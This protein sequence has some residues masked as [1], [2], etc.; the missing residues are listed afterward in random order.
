MKGFPMDAPKATGEVQR[1][2]LVR[3]LHE[4]QMDATLRE[5]E[6][7]SEADAS[8]SSSFCPEDENSKPG[9]S[10]SP[11]NLEA[12]QVRLLHPRH[13]PL[14]IGPLYVALIYAGQTETFMAAPF[15]R[16]S[17]PAMEAE[18]RI[19]R[20][21]PCLRVLSVG[22]ARPLSRALLADSWLVDMLQ[23]DELQDVVA[24]FRRAF[25]GTALP[26]RLLQRTGTLVVHPDDPRHVYC[27]EQAEMM[28]TL[29]LRGRGG[30]LADGDAGPIY[31][32]P[33][34][35]DELPMAAEPRPSYGDDSGEDDDSG[36]TLTS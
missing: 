33:R 13:L 6:L 32:L 35:R 19:A 26:G 22:F 25:H 29:W 30:E 11:S 3:W 23:P 2:T 21:T 12:G 36:E 16:F 8:E 4:W 17:V 27:E 24:V 10:S 9:P 7:S 18:L 14:S 31:E 20:E 1:E 34:D 5:D 28:D 15:S